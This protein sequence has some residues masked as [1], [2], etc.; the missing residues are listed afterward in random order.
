MVLLSQFVCTCCMA[1]FFEVIINDHNYH[2]Y[3]MVNE[4]HKF[5]GTQDCFGFVKC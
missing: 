4:F 5:I 2:K 1:L 3:K